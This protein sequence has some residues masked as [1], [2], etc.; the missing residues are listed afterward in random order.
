L[1]SLS[2]SDIDL[3]KLDTTT[4]EP[5]PASATVN[6]PIVAAILLICDENLPI[7]FCAS[8]NPFCS[9]LVFAD[10]VTDIPPI[11]FPVVI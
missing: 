2:I 5:I 10:I 4:A 9:L 8:F 6:F 1:A 11:T 3:F 7:S